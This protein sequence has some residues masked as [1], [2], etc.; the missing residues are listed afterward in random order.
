MEGEIEAAWALFSERYRPLILA[1][2]RRTVHDQER[3]L[4]VFAHVCQALAADD[5]ARLRRF[6]ERAAHA[7]RFSTW[8]V[9]VVRHQTIDWLRQQEGRRRLR[10]PTELSALQQKIFQHVFGDGRSHAEAYELLCS[11]GDCTLPFAAFLREVAETYRAVE[12]Q[13]GKRGVMHYLVPPPT[14]S[15]QAGVIVDDPFSALPPAKEM[16]A[17]LEAL[18]ADERLALQLFVVDGLPAAEVAR[19]V[20]WPNAKAVYNRTYRTL[21]ALRARLAQHGIGPGDL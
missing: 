20:G 11:S 17:A 9:T 10:V 3:V 18:P 1:T 14:H 15:A 16:T 2:I 7:A 21:A 8:L 12:R 4:D 13:R 5:L 19:L 6:T